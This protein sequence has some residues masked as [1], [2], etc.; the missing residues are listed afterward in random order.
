MSKKI[1]WFV[2]GP[3][4]AEQMALAVSV[5]LTIRDP[6][7]Y[8]VGD[9][10]EQADGVAGEAPDAYLK[11]F[12]LVELDVPVGSEG[13]TKGKAATAAVIKVKLDALGVTYKSAASKADLQK[14]LDQAE[15]DAKASADAKVA[16]LKAKLTEKGI[17]F[18]DVTTQEE[19]QT[20]FDAV[21]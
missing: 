10:I 16:E 5:G 4:S 9:F 15:T 20:L 19:L 14:L 2:R 7:A 11:T 13:E 17:E 12:E 21:E 3:A 18:G 1:L 6:N 8:R